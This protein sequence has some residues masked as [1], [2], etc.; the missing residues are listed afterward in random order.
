MWSIPSVVWNAFGVSGALLFPLVS[1]S[2]YSTRFDNVTWHDSIWALETTKLDQGHYQS[3]ASLANGYIGINVAALGPFF[4][5]DSPVGGD[6]ING[7]PLFDRRQ[8][9]ATVG[10]FWD[11]QPNTNGTNFAWLNQYGGESIISGIPHWGALILE[12]QGHVLNASTDASQ[13]SEFSSTLNMRSGTLSWQY[14][15]TPSGSS[16]FVLAYSMFVHKLYVNRAAIRLHITSKKD[17]KIT[18]YD[19]LDG[20]CAVRTSPIATGVTTKSA[21]IWS[22]VQ[23]ENVQGVAAYVFS[24]MLINDTVHPS[25]RKMADNLGFAGTNASSVAQA[26]S[27]NLKAGTTTLVDKFIGVASTDAFGSPHVVARNASMAGA[28]AGYQKLHNSHVKEW[29]SLMQDDA[30]DSF[31]LPDG[32]LPDDP[33]V[34]EQQIQAVVN[35]FSLLQN[36]VGPNAIAA[37]DGNTNIAAHSISVCGLTSSCY[38]GQIFWDVE[39][40]MAPGLVVAFP[41]AGSQIA[42]Y[43]AG[44]YA[45]AKANIQEAFTSSQANTVFSNNSAIFPWTSGRYGN[46]TG[47]GPCFD[48][49]YHINGDIALELENYYY[50][51]GDRA[52]FESEYFPIYDSIAQVYSDLL[53]LNSTTNLYTLLNATDPDEYANAVDNPTYTM[54]LIQTILDT[55]N[56]FRADFNKSTNALWTTQAANLAIAADTT[57]GVY[58]EYSGMNG[59]IEV[60]Q[61]DVVLIDDFLGYKNPY[62]AADLTYYA[63]RTS[64]GGPG[65]TWAVFSIVSALSSPSGCAD[66]TYDLFSSQPYARPPW[67]QFSEQLTD[68]FAT[69]GGYHPSFPFLTGMGGA[70]RVSVFGY[71]GLTLRADSFNINP[72]LPPQITTLRYRTLYWQGHAISA[73]ANLT[74]T[75]L[76]RLPPSSSLA[77]ANPIYLNTSIPVTISFNTIILPLD[78]Y[79]SPGLTLPNRRPDLLL[80]TPANL[81][82]CHPAT[83]PNTH[84]PGRLPLAAVDGSPATLW[85][86]TDPNT[87]ATLSVTLGPTGIRQISGFHFNWAQAPPLTVSVSFTNASDVLDARAWRNVTGQV[88]VVVSSPWDAAT[89]AEVVLLPGN[90]TNVTL[91]AGI[92]G[93]KTVVLS[94]KGSWADD[95]VGASVAEF[96][97]LEA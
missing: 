63:G 97:V 77:T 42:R 72:T 19:V 9:F 52:T 8:T 84:Q 24:T 30:V 39:V 87:T 92:W 38:A 94:M 65:M 59:S 54:I 34:V 16:G 13:I 44:H 82:Q 40:W 64:V 62:T 79:P 66:Y 15:W 50:V 47:V 95:G 5:P 89:A 75:T 55:A 93:G 21:S 56:R 48:Y 80:T 20:D 60:K 91:G 36:T 46:C 23:L 7:W 58:L 83:S 76:H 27:L 17:S 18:V 33:N 43:R 2:V 26:V 35:T 1:A 4:E 74:H 3:R 45:Q 49:E 11:E 6:D 28:A 67:F 29:N 25:T 14:T 41:E 70:S 37:A 61:A 53:H 12:F 85:Q 96:A 73:T 88:D 51:T 22:G 31:H 68:E 71:L 10:G 78:P 86:P 90:E 81:A 57:A 32:D 69:N